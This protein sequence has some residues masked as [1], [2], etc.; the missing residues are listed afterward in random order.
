MLSPRALESNTYFGWCIGLREDSPANAKENIRYNI[1]SAPSG[2]I[3]NPRQSMNW[4]IFWVTDNRGRF[5]QLFTVISVHFKKW[6]PEPRFSLCQTTSCRTEVSFDHTELSK[7]PILKSRYF[8]VLMGAW[9]WSTP[10]VSINEN[11]RISTCGRV[12]SWI[13][14]FITKRSSESKLERNTP[15]A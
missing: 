14:S 12:H 7:V 15:S 9:F 13:Q 5:R 2:R 4:T 6:I 1:F 8:P 3:A 11:I 10:C